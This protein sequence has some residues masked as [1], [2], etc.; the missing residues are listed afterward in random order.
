MTEATAD[1]PTVSTNDIELLS[2]NGRRIAVRRIAWSTSESRPPIVFLHEGLGSIS[3]WRDFPEAVAAATGAPVLLYDRLGH[4][5]SDP[6]AAPRTPDY[7]D[8]EALDWLPQV[9]DACGVEQA[10]LFGH[11]DGGTIALLFAAAYPERVNA[12][13]CEAAHVFVEEKAIRGIREAVERFREA[14]LEDRLVRHHGDQARVL[15]YAWADTWLSAEFRHWNVEE[16][17]SQI[18]CP[19]LLLQGEDDEYATATH[20]SAIAYKISGP[21]ETGLL[22]NCAHV[23]HSQARAVV[24]E[25]VTAFLRPIFA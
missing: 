11:S 20:L 17:L 6:L 16:R 3:Q 7:L 18:R 19:L 12:I 1:R 8:V 22:M 24:L 23:P 13:I 14:D 9:L 21:V 4:G 15:F 10:C 25:R 5:R 2:V